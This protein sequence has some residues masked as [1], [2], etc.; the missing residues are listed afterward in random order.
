MSTLTVTNAG[1]NAVAAALASGQSIKI[2]YVALGTGT[3]GTPA[4]ATQLAA[5]VFRKAVASY[6]AGAVAGEELI[7]GYISPNDTPG[8]AI[9]EVGFFIGGSA[10]ANTGTLLFYGLYSHTHTNLESLQLVADS[11]L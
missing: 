1:L 8:T 6:A 2:S 5:E 10:S 3:Q 4:T 11:V 7:T 9:T